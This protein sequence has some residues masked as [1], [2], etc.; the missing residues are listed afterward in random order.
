MFVLILWD[1]WSNAMML[2]LVQVHTT[3]YTDGDKKFCHS[4]QKSII[5][6]Y[7]KLYL[8]MQYGKLIPERGHGDITSNT[9][10]HTP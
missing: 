4:Q 7:S 3:T 10:V 5:Q 2:F 1:K 8:L 9:H 6:T